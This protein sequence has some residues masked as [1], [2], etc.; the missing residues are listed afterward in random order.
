MA[1]HHQ[2]GVI[3]LFVGNVR[4]NEKV[5][6]RLE[7]LAGVESHDDGYRFRFPSLWRPSYHCHVKAVE[8]ALG[9]SNRDGV[10]CE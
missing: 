1:T 3:N 5:T 6:V 7:M 10:A 8:V 2:D 4:P 9:A